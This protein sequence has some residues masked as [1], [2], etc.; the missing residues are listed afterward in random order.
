LQL[1]FALVI[2]TAGALLVRHSATPAAEL[3]P[4]A[5]GHVL[6][7]AVPEASPAFRSARYATLLGALQ[8][9][10]D[11]DSVSLT[12]PGSVVG[13]GTV[14]VATTD[15]GVCPFG[16][17]FVPWHSVPAT[18]RIV[19]ADSFQALGV[20]LVAGRGI[21]SADGWD[22]PRV[23]V[24]N[25]ALALRHFQNGEAIGRRLLLGDDPRSWHTVVGIVDDPPPT[26][27]GAALLPV[28]TVYASVLQ[29]PPRRVELLLRPRRGHA[30]PPSVDSIVVRLVGSGQVV[31]AAEA[32]LLRSQ[33]AP[34][35][36]FADAFA[37]QGWAMLVIALLSSL[38]Q[39]RLWV[40]SLCP[41]LGL[42]RALGA[43]RRRILGSILL[44]A[45]AVGL[46]GTAVGLWFGPA[47]WSAVGSLIAGLPA[48]EG[49]I[50]LRFA[51]LLVGISTLGA[52]LPAWRAARAAPAELLA[53]AHT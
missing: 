23:A 50:V 20:H 28:F 27:L 33:R 32:Q 34:E 48:W 47:V 44:R 53:Q 5:P 1:G 41:E 9:M 46:A 7:A 31:R 11:F 16:G 3:S 8:G 49:A 14:S 17:L 37:D 12:A 10:Q 25:R 22:A 35:A 21:T 26:G 2:L 52:A 6:E 45:A 42:K 15:C 40:R 30:V 29:H 51:A 19:S 4:S 24:V 36:W 38:V 43:R 39:M 18:H 13:L